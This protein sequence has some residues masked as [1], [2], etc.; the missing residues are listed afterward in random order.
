MTKSQSINNLKAKKMKF[1][2]RSLPRPP[3]QKNLDELTI[4]NFKLGKRLGRGRFGNVY[5]AEEK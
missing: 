2:S 3:K 5:L 4:E 1:L